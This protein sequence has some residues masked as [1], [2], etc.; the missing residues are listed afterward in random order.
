MVASGNTYKEKVS[1][2]ISW[3]HWFS[4]FNIIAAMLLGTRYITHSDWPATLIG[5]LYLLLSWVGHFG[6]LV[7]GIYILII[8][9]ASFLIP[10][11]RLM[12]LFG[13]L[14]ATVGLTALLLDTYAYQ[15]VDLHLSPL[16]WDLLLSGDK[17]ELNA[18]W[19][20]LFVVVPVI[21]LLELMCSEWV[22]RKLRKLTRKHVGGP[23][24]FVFGVCFLGSHLIYIWADANLYRPVTMQR[25]NFPFSYP[26]TAKT[27]MEKHGLL[28]RQ[29]YTKR[30]AEQGV[31][32]SELVRYPIQKLSF[33]DQGTGQNLMIIMV[34][35]L[36][37]DMITPMVMPNLSA[38]A[39]QNLDFTDNYSSSNSDSTGVFGLLYGLPSGY[40][41][42][43]RAENKSPILLNTLQNRGYHFGL[44]SGENFELPIYREAIFANTKLATT[45]SEHPDQV[46]SDAHALKD[47]QHW[48]VKQ[49]IGQPW[50]SFLELTSVQQFKEGEHYKP[51]FTPSLGSNAINEKGVDSTLLLKN[52]YRN[53]AFHIDE[54]LGRVFANLEAKG[55]LDN[56][57]VVIASNH[58]TEFNE[59]GN[60]T[61]GSGSNYSKY[62]I[63]VPLI[64]HWPDHAAQDVTR[65][66]SNLDVVPTLM[67]SLL[68]VATA[69]S[70][71]SS[72]VSLFDQNNDRRW[73][74]AGNDDDIVVVQ[75]K[76]TTV[77]DKY[78]NYN[79]YDNNYQLKDEG[80]PKL[81]TLMQ[82]MN[83][84]KRFYEP[85]PYEK[86]N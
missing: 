78:G 26:M 44:F 41:N 34:D 46:P 31:K 30:R 32:N 16:V 77:V 37:S 20:Y 66:T 64:I 85:K 28:D 69:P 9:P 71:Y 58:G 73:I 67:E 65:L 8:F 72:G 27:F 35:S 19:Q 75:K 82:V 56:T 68:N 48:L 7:F 51:R 60:N 52:S 2:L 57:I 11:Q 53:A 42:S 43:I 70:N 22:W 39:E 74:L 23:I 45:D 10:S 40:A 6:F 25:S 49:K 59:T 33:N 36:R 38:F 18:R 63:K 12:R 5:Q 80:K 1:Q 3:G 50:F 81:S 29:E 55:V 14:V 83:E 62:Q 61:W 24:A 13:V 86:N 15:S 21:F 79:V 54:M 84:L 4:F 76:Q 17:T 47:W